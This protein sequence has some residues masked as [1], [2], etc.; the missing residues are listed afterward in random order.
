[1]ARLLGVEVTEG[2]RI[3]WLSVA[4]VL[5]GSILYGISVAWIRFQSMI[6][7]A[8]TSATSGLYGFYADVGRIPLEGVADAIDLAWASFEAELP[9]FE[10]LAFVVAV[11]GVSIAMI[12][13]LFLARRV[14][15]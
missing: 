10:I 12:G 6:F 15:P 1:M 13:L 7:D 14:T 2:T 4:T 3:K 9:A 11:A 8:W 5:A